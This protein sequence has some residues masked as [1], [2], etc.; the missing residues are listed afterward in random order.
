[1]KKP[2]RAMNAGCIP[3]YHGSDNYPEPNV[4]N[5]DAIIFIVMGKDNS[6]AIKLI[7]ELN[8]DKKKYMDFACQKRFIVGAEDVIWEYYERL[9]KKLKEIIANS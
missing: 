2:S 6:N 3:I 8:S 1:M 7:S 4:L 9:E 5:Q